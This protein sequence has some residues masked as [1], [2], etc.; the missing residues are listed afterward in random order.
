MNKAWR[1]GL[2]EMPERIRALPVSDKGYPV[3]YF[4]SWIDGKPDFR[5]ADA[6]KLMPAAR[7]GKCWICGEQMGRYKAFVAG[8]MCAITRASAEP[9]S[10]LDCAKWAAQACPFLI[11][12]KAQRRDANLPEEAQ[13]PGGIFITR[14]PGVCMVWTT[15]SFRANRLANGV[16]FTMGPAISVDWYAE[17]RA[18]TRGEV[19]ESMNSGLPQL[20]ELAKEDGDEAM[21]EL[22][23]MAQ[24]AM[25]HFPERDP[26][27][28]GFY[29]LSFAD[30]A[31][32]EG[33]DWLGACIVHALDFEDALHEAKAQGVNPGGAVRGGMLPEFAVPLAKPYLGRLLTREEVEAFDRSVAESKPQ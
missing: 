33:N 14:N 9:P 8:P 30:E 27:M 28:R 1:E 19:M 25:Q 13:D 12:P 22:S 4:A 15:E 11:L 23:I 18:A 31:R 5:C 20:V 24:A 32:P 16:V 21:R 7:D 17:G 26:A 2:P 6:S 10:H 29:F 3:P